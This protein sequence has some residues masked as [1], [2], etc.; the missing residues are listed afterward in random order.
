MIFFLKTSLLCIVGELEEEGSVDVSVS[1]KRQ[2]TG[3]QG[4]VTSYM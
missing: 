1:A 2:V 4:Q 3:N